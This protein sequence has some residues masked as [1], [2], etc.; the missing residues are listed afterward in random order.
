MCHSL[1]LTSM[2]NSKSILFTCLLVVIVWWSWWVR[3]CVLDG[4][5][6]NFRV[7]A[8]H[9]PYGFWRPNSRSQDWQQAPLSAETSHLPLTCDFYRQCLKLS[10]LHW[11]KALWDSLAVLLLLH[12]APFP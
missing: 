4:I 3:V 1:V 12:S 9:R 7:D 8:P 10:G 2:G 6:T 5:K 11:T